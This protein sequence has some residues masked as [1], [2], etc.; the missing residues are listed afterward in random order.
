MPAFTQSEI[1]WS[2]LDVQALVFGH[3]LASVEVEQREACLAWL[4]RE[5]YQVNSLDCSLGIKIFVEQFGEMFHW[6]EQFGY[7]LS[8]ERRNLNAVHDGFSLEAPVSGRIVLE[9]YRPDLLHAEDPEWLLGFLSIASE[10]TRFQLASG[11]RFLSLLVMPKNS[12]LI[13][14]RVETVIVPHAHTGMG[15]G[16]TFE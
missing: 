8:V 9:L 16:I 7:E 6:V 10:H 15:K 4:K 14:Q 13:G 11:K 5:H 2:R 12:D 3:G 1:L